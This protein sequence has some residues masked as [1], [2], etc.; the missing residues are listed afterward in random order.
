MAVL[1]SNFRVYGVSGLRVVDASVFPRIPGFFIV[2]SVYMVGEKAADAILSDAGRA[3]VLP[4]ATFTRAGQQPRKPVAAAARVALVLLFAGVVALFAT[5]APESAT[6]QKQMK[7]LKECGCTWDSAYKGHNEARKA[8]M[9]TPWQRFTRRDY[10]SR[11]DECL[12]KRETPSGC[13]A[14]AQQ[15]DQQKKSAAGG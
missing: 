1:D 6:E 8:P 3:A 14:D 4:P 2:T 9:S 7:A 5:T 15:S 10:R 12:G 13:D 11:M